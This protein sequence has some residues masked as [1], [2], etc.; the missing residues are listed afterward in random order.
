MEEGRQFD[1]ARS[2]D[3][4]LHRE[5]NVV[6]LRTNTSVTRCSQGVE[7]PLTWYVILPQS[8]VHDAQTCSFST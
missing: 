7:F 4:L 2:D 3:A 8:R 5:K 6:V 1:S